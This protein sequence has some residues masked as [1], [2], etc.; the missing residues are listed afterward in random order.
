MSKNQDTMTKQR[1]GTAVV[2]LVRPS[3]LDGLQ[4][5]QRVTSFVLSHCPS[6]F[7]QRNRCPREWLRTRNCSMGS[8]LECGGVQMWHIMLSTASGLAKLIVLTGVPN[9]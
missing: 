8:R 5:A 2:G 9:L 7:I 4:V 1:K 6:D 3:K